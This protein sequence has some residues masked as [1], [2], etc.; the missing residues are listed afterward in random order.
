MLGLRAIGHAKTA[1]PESLKPR[2]IPDV[3]LRS[4]AS[5]GDRGIEVFIA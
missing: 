1:Q 3:A 4:I 5:A 2:T